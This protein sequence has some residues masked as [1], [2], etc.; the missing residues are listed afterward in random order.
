MD[1]HSDSGEIGKGPNYCVIKH[2]QILM[3]MIITV[4]QEIDAVLSAFQRFSNLFLTVF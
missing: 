1:S 3:V 4:A 2:W